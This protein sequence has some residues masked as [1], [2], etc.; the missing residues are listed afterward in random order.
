MTDRIILAAF[1]RLCRIVE[2]LPHE[3]YILLRRG[4]RQMLVDPSAQGSRFGLTMVI[5]QLEYLQGDM[6]ECPQEV[7]S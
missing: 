4:W 7:P 6:I 2:R 3:R 5:E 1:V